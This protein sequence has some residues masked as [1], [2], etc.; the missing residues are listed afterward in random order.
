VRGVI[1]G[2]GIFPLGDAEV[3]EGGTLARVGV[4]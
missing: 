1:D 2:R 4:I 3:Y